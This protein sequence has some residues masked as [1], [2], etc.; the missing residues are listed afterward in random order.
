MRATG[1]SVRISAPKDRAA[2]AIAAVRPPIPPSGN[3]HEP[4]SP[5]PTSPILWWA[6]TNAVPGERGPA[7]VPI[8]PDTESTP[9]TSGD[10]K[11]SSRRSATLIENRRV[12]SATPRTPSPFICQANRAWPS[13]SAGRVLPSRGGTAVSSGAST[14]AN[15]WSQSSHRVMAS[16]SAVENLAI[17]A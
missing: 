4:S 2:D 14:S 1:A 6:I 13:R 11:K 9:S 15:P 12:T 16:A 7:H 3:P 8:T 17:S 10:S 5:S